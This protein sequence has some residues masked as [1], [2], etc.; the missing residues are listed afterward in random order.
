MNIQRNVLGNV[1]MNNLNITVILNNLNF[2]H[3]SSQTTIFYK[4][5]YRYFHSALIFSPM[6][7]SS[8]CIISISLSPS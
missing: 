4:Q 8:R 6:S 1:I 3:G 5:I 2:I 7:F